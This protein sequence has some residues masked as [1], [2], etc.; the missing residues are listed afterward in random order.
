M[1]LPDFDNF[2]GDIGCQTG[3]VARLDEEVQLLWHLRC[4]VVVEVRLQLRR[5]SVRSHTGKRRRH[6]MPPGYQI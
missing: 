2:I 4:Q 1:H 6:D 5:F 3:E